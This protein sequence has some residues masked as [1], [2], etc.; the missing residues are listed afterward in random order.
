MNE[1]SKVKKSFKCLEKES[2]HDLDKS[3]DKKMLP[4]RQFGEN[5]SSQLKIALFR[6]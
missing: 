5:I 1:L 3:E 2:K 6:Y 4:N